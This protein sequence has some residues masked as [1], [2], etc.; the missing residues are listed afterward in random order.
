MSKHSLE[1]KIEVVEFV[2]EKNNSQREAV[3]RF[4]ISKGEIQK[5]ID[6]YTNHGI[7]G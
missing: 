4:R 6:A 7:E 5:W 1:A 3:R 2:L